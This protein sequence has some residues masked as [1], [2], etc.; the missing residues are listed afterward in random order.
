[1]GGARNPFAREKAQVHHMCFRRDPDID[2]FGTDVFEVFDHNNFNDPGGDGWQTVSAQGR[3]V[4]NPR[5]PASS[6]FAIS[7][8]PALSAPA[9]G[10]RSSCRRTPG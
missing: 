3:F 9:G 5:P 1:M 8:A 7:P 4:A 6:A 10:M 2:G